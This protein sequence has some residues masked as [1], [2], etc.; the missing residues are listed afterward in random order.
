MFDL[1]AK[2]LGQLLYI[3]YNTIA[4]RNYGLSLVLFTILIKL[5]L[6]PLNN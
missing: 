3:I 6:Q 1:I 5:A 2:V 4:F